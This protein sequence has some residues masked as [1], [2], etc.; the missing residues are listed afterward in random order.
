VPQLADEQ[1]TPSTQWPLSHSPPLPQTW[2]R[3][4]RPQ[5]AALHTFPGAQSVSAPQA[6]LQ[7]LPLQA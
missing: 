6:E 3:R 4:L 1:Q 5:E 2:P 7:V